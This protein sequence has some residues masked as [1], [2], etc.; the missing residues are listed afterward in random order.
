[1]NQ[2]TDAAL[3]SLDNHLYTLEKNINVLQL[4][5]EHFSGDL[6]EMRWKS[7]T[8]EREAASALQKYEN[9]LDLLTESFWAA[10]IAARASAE[11]LYKEKLA[12]E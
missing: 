5:H 12:G 2:I 4:L 8:G 6:T 11:A 9:A 1:M 10:Y 7:L 3:S